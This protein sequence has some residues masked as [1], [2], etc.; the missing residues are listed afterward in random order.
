MILILI[1]MVFIYGWL[2]KNLFNYFKNHKEIIKK[3]ISKDFKLHMNWH[4]VLVIWIIFI[5]S[6]FFLVD[7]IRILLSYYPETIIEKVCFIGKIMCMFIFILTIKHLRD[8]EKERHLIF[9]EK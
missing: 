5:S 1:L 4:L 7:I 8:E 6:I 2:L 3:D 9:K